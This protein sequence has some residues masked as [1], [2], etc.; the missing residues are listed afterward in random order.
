MIAGDFSIITQRTWSEPVEGS[1]LSHEE[2][3][4]E[5]GVFAK[6]RS[7]MECSRWCQ[8]GNECTRQGC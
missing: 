1:G 3:R 6:A 7:K 5:R 4:G 2:T 8:M